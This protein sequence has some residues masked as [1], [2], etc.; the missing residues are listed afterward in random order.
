MT[1]EER[2]IQAYQEL[3]NHTRDD[4]VGVLKDGSPN[5]T[6]CAQ[7]KK[8]W[9]CCEP[10]YCDLAKDHAKEHWGTVLEDTPHYQTGKTPLPL[11]GPDGC[12]IAPHLR[13]SCSLHHCQINSLGIKL[14]CPEWTERYFQL[15]SI[16]EE[17]ELERWENANPT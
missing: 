14:H 4:C 15:R 9:K 13:P 10:L 7:S 3:A 5:P 2:L 1:L 8:Q 12:S 6:A 11:M 17:L 16:V